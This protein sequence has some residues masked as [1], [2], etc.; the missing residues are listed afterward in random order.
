MPDLPDLAKP[1]YV[2]RVNRAI[3]YVVEHL[4]E[5]LNLDDV[6]R[7]AAFSPYH[8]HRIFR[9]LVGETLNAFIRR[10]RLERAL[11]LLSHG[12]RASL[13]EVALACGFSSS[14][15]FSRS[16]RAHFGVPPRAFDLD[17]YRAS[18][19]E[20][21]R[22]DRLPPG[23]NP[24]GFAVTLRDAPP[25]HVAY[26]RVLQ[27]F[28]PGKVSAA[29]RR[30]ERW[31]ESRDLA[32]GQW[33][34]YMWEDPDIV[35]LDKCRYDVAVEVPEPVA[36]DGEV[37]ARAFPAMLLAELDIAGSIELEQ[38]ALDWLYHTWLP[39]S[40]YEP[41]HQPAFEAWNG[42][43]FAHGDQHFELRVQLPVVPR[44]TAIAGA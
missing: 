12:D 1:D 21:L 43:P 5:P 32:G 9:G 29:A 37:G 15:S 28:Q 31:A 20:E 17:T 38:R 8:F 4:G 24:D 2:A 19:R 27:P 36:V 23:E 30:L 35:P 14:S 25:R 7:A 39:H 34:G 26:I 3:D 42:R 40:A 16:F 11:Y 44:G 41:D 22:L 13:T 18:R 33:L 6:A 10:L